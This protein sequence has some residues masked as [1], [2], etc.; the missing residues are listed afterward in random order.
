MF[1]N[2]QRHAHIKHWKKDI[3]A[4]NERRHI[5]DDD[6]EKKTHKNKI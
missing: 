6:E 4:Y 3:D 2:T 1:T 5:T